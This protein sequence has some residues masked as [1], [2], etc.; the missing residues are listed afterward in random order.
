MNNIQLTVAAINAMQPLDIVRDDAV[1]ERFIQIYD[2]LWGGGEAA[3]EKESIYFNAILRDDEKKQKATKFSIF[4]AFIDLAVCGLSLEPGSRALC[5]L[6]GRNY[7]IGT[8]SNGKG[9]YEGRLVLTVSGY[10]ELVLRARSGQI[11]HADNPVMVYEEDDF[12]FSDNNGRKQV[13]Y[14]CKIPHTSNHIVACY[15][16]ITRADGSVDYGIMLEEDWLRLQEYSAKNNRR[17]N[18]ENGVWEENPNELYKQ[19]EGMID[20]GF[21]AA[22]C[23]KHAF[24]TYPKVRIGR[25]TELESQQPD[26]PQDEDFYGVSK[27][28]KPAMPQP[29]PSFAPQPD[30]SAG[31]TIDPAAG[32]SATSDD[33]TF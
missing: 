18:K 30:M 1:R 22:K 23:I 5:Y 15:M 6:V 20:T 13:S 16:R 28:E 25:G 17:W 14:T 10:G 9:I 7:K 4:T 8:E 27:A 26:E 32:D 31:V 2:T 24:K 3:Y 11:Q 21:L 19:R 12:C 29:Q 33:G